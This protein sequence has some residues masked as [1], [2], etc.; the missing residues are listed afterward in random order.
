MKPSE[1]E[2]DGMAIKLSASMRRKP[3]FS[4]TSYPDASAYQ[5]LPEDIN[6]VALL[7]EEIEEL[8]MAE[9]VRRQEIEFA[10]K[11]SHW[12]YFEVMEAITPEDD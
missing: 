8:K 6:E 3:L 11:H 7:E 1:K 12:S 9:D 4:Q 10:V 5:V 2:G